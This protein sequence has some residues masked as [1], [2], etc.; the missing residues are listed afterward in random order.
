MNAVPPPLAILG[1]TA[2]A[3]RIMV[4]R[5]QRSV[6]AIPTLYCPHLYLDCNVV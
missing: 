4:Q 1:K 5:S 2:H 6:Y 3:N